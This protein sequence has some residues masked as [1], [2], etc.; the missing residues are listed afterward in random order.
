M[1]DLNILKI[2]K[3]GAT[4]MLSLKCWNNKTLYGIR[5]NI[6]IMCYLDIWSQESLEWPN[7]KFLSPF[8]SNGW[9]LLAKQLSLSNSSGTAPAYSWI[10]NFSF[11]PAHGIIQISWSHYSRGTR[12]HPPLLMLQRLLAMAPG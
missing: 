7:C 10:V 12:G 8:C 11:L 6:N 1:T 4:V 5:H 9:G 2:W 3:L